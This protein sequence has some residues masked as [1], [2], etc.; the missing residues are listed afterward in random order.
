MPTETWG[1]NSSNDYNNRT[2]DSFIRSGFPNNNYS[3]YTYLEIGTDNRYRPIIRFTPNQDIAGATVVSATLYL[4]AY[5]IVN[6]HSVEA[7]RVLQD[8]VNNQVTWNIWKTGNSW[9][10]A[11]CA[12]A[13]D[14]EG[15]DSLSADRHVTALGTTSF[16]D[17]GDGNWYTWNITSL[18]QGW[19]DGSIKEYGLLLK[20][21]NEVSSNR[22]YIYSSESTQD[23]K[24]PYLEIEYSIGWSGKVMGQ[25]D[26]AK[27]IGIDKANIAKVMGV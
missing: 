14:A 20:S 6:N 7:Y 16:P 13:D 3:S 25:T 9:F 15:D 23:G 2:E 5:T 12:S 22:V 17:T 21:S 27:I 24:R 8:W 19:V 18:V 11:G 26:P 1:E 4:Y 10:T